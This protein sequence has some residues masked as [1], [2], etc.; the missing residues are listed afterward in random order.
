[1][2]LSLAT[3]ASAYENPYG[4]YYS[5]EVYYNGDELESDAAKPV[6]KIGEPF[7]VSI[8]MTVYQECKV[9][10]QIEDLG[11]GLDMDNFIVVEGPSQLGESISRIY[12]ENESHTYEWTLKPTEEWAGGTIPIDIHYEIIEKGQSEPLVNAGFTAVLPY[13]S[14]EYY[15][16]PETT[17]AEPPE[18]DTNQTPAFTLPAA[19]LAI[20]LVALRKK[21]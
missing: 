19:L 18:T 6:L 2:I 13:I 10:M 17:P 8:E 7:T 15:D 3:V 16:A 11:T 5:Y 4:K 9:Y 1:M 20:A 12:A 14:T 21:C